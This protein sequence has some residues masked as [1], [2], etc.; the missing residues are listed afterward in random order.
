MLLKAPPV[1]AGVDVLLNKESKRETPTL[2]TFT[3]KQR[4]MGTDASH[5][6]TTNPKNT[7]SWLKRLMGKRFSDPV[8]QHDLPDLPYK[9]VEGP[10]G[11]CL[12]EVQY[13]GKTTHQT[14]EQLMAAMLVD[15]KLNAEKE[16]GEEVKECVLAVPTF[17]T[18][19][20]R[21]AMLDAAQIAGWNCLRLL[22]DTTATALAYGIYKTDLPEKDPVNVVFVDIGHAATQV[23]CAGLGCAGGK[24]WQ[25]AGVIWVFLLK[26]QAGGCDWGW[27]VGGMAW[28]LG[29]WVGQVGG[30]FSGR[31]LT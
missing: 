19:P 16:Q 11:E 17:Y 5:A 26:G 7:I 8:V 18:E 20:E 6:L 12:F 10:K 3:A 25:W 27:A 21:H 15:L 28:Q 31:L 13:L 24:G 1:G 23:C 30:Q 14:A 9:V 29:G 2:V 22:N 4:Q